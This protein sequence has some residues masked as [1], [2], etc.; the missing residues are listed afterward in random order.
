M[1]RNIL[2]SNRIEEKRNKKNIRSQVVE[3]NLN[4]IKNHFDNNIKNIEQNFK[5]VDNLIS[6]NEINQSKNILRS[7]IVFLESALDFYLHKL[8]KCGLIKIFNGIW[9]K[10]ERYNNLKIEMKLLDIAIKNPESNDWL[11]SYIN[12]K[13]KTEVYL[14][15][16]SIKKQLNLLGIDFDDVINKVFNENEK[17]NSNPKQYIN[18]LFNRRNEIA[19][20]SDRNH[21]DAKQNDISKDYVLRNIEF[22]KKVS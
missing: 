13:I 4:E 7:Q 11:L 17:D 15:L 12:E 6:I 20:Q 21:S 22:V 8:S 16:D 14:S 19:H 5:I 9:H 2:I 1:S 18:D 3:F 10:T